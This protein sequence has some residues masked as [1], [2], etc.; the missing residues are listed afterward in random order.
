MENLFLF[1]YAITLFLPCVS[2]LVVVI[3]GLKNR[4][5]S[6]GPFKPALAD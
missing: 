4:G 2:E 3:D 5:I 1:D 6:Q